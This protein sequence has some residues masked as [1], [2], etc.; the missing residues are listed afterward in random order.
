MGRVTPWQQARAAQSASPS[1]RWLPVTAWG[2]SASGT[3]RPA[4]RANC[5]VRVTF[6]PI[7]T[8]GRSGTLTVSDDALGSP[9][10]VALSGTG[11]QP[12]VTPTPTSLSFGN[13]QVGTTSYRTITLT[14]SGSASM[15]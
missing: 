4:A 14:N 3:T 9:H 2:N 6:L 15:S 10:T 8:G 12:A 11:T 7:T 13:Q 1:P 5:T